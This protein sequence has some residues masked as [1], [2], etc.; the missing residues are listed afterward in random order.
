MPKGTE[1]RLLI[2]LSASR[3]PRGRRYPPVGAR[4]RALR[5]SAGAILAVVASLV[6]FPAT[7][8]GAEEATISAEQNGWFWSSNSKTTF[9]GGGVSGAISLDDGPN[10][11]GIGLTEANALSPISTG[12]MAVSM[13]NGSSDMRSYIK[14]DLGELPFGVE[15]TNFDMI[16]TTSHPTDTDHVEQHSSFEGKA[17]GTANASAASIV[18]CS[19]TVPWGAAEGDPVASTTVIAPDPREGRNEF[20][21]TTSRDEPV[22][23]CSNQALGVPSR[24]GSFWRFDLTAMANKW[25]SLELF[26]EGVA[27]LPVNQNVAS[28][29][30]V[31]FHGKPL[32]VRTDEA[33]TVVVPKELGARAAV[34]YTEVT[35]EEPPTQG[36]AGPAGPPGPSGPTIIPPSDGGGV[37]TPPQ[38]GG[39]GV[40]VP[41]AQAGAAETPAWLYALIPIGLLGLGLT[42]SAIGAEGVG[43]A[44]RNRVAALLRQRRL[45]GA[46]DVSE[47]TP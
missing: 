26:N 14:F 8:A 36:P 24:D 47:P 27:L 38:Q 6:I 42:S 20:E 19:V 43:I 45:A 17:P 7:S 13:K 30:T 2:T 10:S 15:F 34:S 46:S 23:D 31:E 4:A 37:T 18:A 29:W 33:S 3:L 9:I 35:E 1:R 21:I 40:L 25:A 39:G 44:S 32:T 41:V 16:L 12:H 28:T 5:A 22:Y 11:S